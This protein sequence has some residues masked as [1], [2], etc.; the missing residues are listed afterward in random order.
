V[1]VPGDTLSAIARR[2]N[3]NVFTLG[4]RNNIFNLNLIFPGQVLCIP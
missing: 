2:Y 1:V 3:V 4:A